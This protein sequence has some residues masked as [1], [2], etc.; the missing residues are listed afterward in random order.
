MIKQLQSQGFCPQEENQDAKRSM[1]VFMLYAKAQYMNELS[2]VLVPIN[3]DLN[4]LLTSR[5]GTSS[6]FQR[7][8]L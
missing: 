1:Y 6:Q 8:I 5:T 7:F 4:A 3:L 2:T